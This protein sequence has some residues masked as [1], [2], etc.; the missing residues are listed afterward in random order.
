MR[1]SLLV[2]VGICLFEL[3]LFAQKS[4]QAS[5]EPGDALSSESGTTTGQQPQPQARPMVMQEVTVTA[6]RIPE[7]TKDVPQAVSLIGEEKL[8]HEFPMA[9]NQIVRETTGIF[10]PLVAAQGSPILR[11]QIGNRVLY[12]WNDL[13]LN[14]GALFSGPN[15]NFNQIPL[16]AVEHMEIIHGPG[17]VQYGSGAV[18]GLIDI[19]TPHAPFT[20]SWSTGGTLQGDYSSVN[21]GRTTSGSLWLGS[22]RFS[23]TGGYTTQD[24][25]N[26]STPVGAENNTGFNAN[27]G[28][29]DVGIV[30]TANQML[31]VSWIQ[32]RRGDV[33][34]YASSL[35]NANET[36]RNYN[37]FELR[38]LAKVNYSVD[39][40]LSHDNGL[41]LYLYTQYY[42]QNRYT[43]TVSPN[44]SAWTTQYTTLTTS[45]QNIYGGGLQDSLRHGPVKVAFGV[46]RRAE[47]LASN[48][49][50]FTFTRAT[51]TTAQS[52]P[53]GN[54]PPGT[55][56]VTDGYAIATLTPTSRL[57][58]TVGGRIE[59]THIHSD[60]RPQDVLIPYFTTD[61]LLLVKTWNAETWSVG[62][63][64]NVRGNWSLA[65]NIGTAFRAP[66]FSDALSTGT[67]V[68]SSGTISV[69]NK[70][71]GPERSID[72][73]IGPRYNAGD[74][75]ISVVAY[76]NMLS[77]VI[78]TQNAPYQV[79]INNN[80]T[81]Y[82]ATYSSNAD[83][84][85]VA[86]AEVSL[87]KRF[88]RAWTFI[89]NLTYTHGLDTTQSTPFRFIPPTNGTLALQ[90]TSPGHKWWTAASV[91]LD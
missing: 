35:L 34:Y 13:P 61:D 75:K 31:R 87:S 80:T 62:A 10:S 58:I 32:D 17:A 9:P 24:I 45:P 85:Y 5:P 72:Y 23:F 15:P 69:P 53:L 73:E 11:G 44:T 71:V 50:M 19:F 41:N 27:G 20:A 43:I 81:C 88:L 37:S 26:Y 7:E 28:Y 66:T 52:I 91:I 36:P 55:Y 51:D 14:N 56:H 4:G 74:L 16:V 29:V 89:G 54:V 79:C 33:G 70:N 22:K 12:L 18:G 84:G 49:T 63:I 86:G 76:A 21:G 68:Y 47:D 1:R 64:Y 8:D 39:K 38:G 67:P 42:D 65:G 57:S 6:T 77:H 60:P 46:D 90:Y 82:Q 2:L 3:S 83:A 25:G 48:K 30:V 59:S 78:V 40:F